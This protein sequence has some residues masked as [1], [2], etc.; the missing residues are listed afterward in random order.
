MKPTLVV[1]GGGASGFFCAI[2]AA[3][4]QPNLN[5]II[6]EKNNKLLSKVKISGGGRCNVTH[7]C[8]QIAELIT[9][10]PRGTNFVKKTFHWFNPNHTVEWFQ[11]RGIQLHTET[12]GR[13]FPTTNTSQSIIDCFLSEANRHQIH[14]ITN[15]EVKNIVRVNNGFAL[16]TSIPRSTVLDLQLNYSNEQQT[17]LADVVCVAVGGY[18]KK[19]QFSWLEALGHTIQLPVPSLFTFNIPKHPITSLMGIAVPKVQV[20]VIASKLKTEGPLLITHWGLSGPAILKLSAIGARHFSLSNYHFTISINWLNDTSEEALRQQWLILRSQLAHQKM[21]NK[22]PFHLPSRLWEFLLQHSQVDANKQWANCTSKEQNLLITALTNFQL[23]VQ[24]KTT[25][26][27]EFVTCGGISLNEINPNTMESKLLPNL[28]FTGEVLDIDGVTGGF[29][30]QNAWTTGWIAAQ[31][32]AS[33][34]T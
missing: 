4:L 5:I 1:I 19:A 29:N 6:L 14:I 31:A 8:F 15:A 28:Y 24:G 27:E 13:M 21:G 18:P 25:F 12:D 3:K 20:K 30:F 7:D 17:L 11:S 16:S 26:K 22:N 32:I 34:A 23:N 9:H 2:N 10:Y 33:K